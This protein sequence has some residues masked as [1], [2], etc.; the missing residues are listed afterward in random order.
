MDTSQVIVMVPP[1]EVSLL[2]VVV[3]AARGVAEGYTTFR[4]PATGIGLAVVNLR[5]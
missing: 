2:Q 5:E 3:V 4:A 1:T